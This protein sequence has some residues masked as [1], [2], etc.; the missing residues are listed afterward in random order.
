MFSLQVYVN[1]VSKEGGRAAETVIEEHFGGGKRPFLA[2]LMLAAMEMNTEM[3]MKCEGES[4]RTRDSTRVAL[5]T[6]V[7]CKTVHT[8]TASTSA[9]I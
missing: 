9:T 7:T 6:T 1:E 4:S 8:W 2:S 5:C 3:K